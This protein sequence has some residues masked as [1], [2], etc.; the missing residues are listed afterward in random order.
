[1]LESV[2]AEIDEFCGF[3][4]AEDADDAAVVV[5]TIVLICKFLGHRVTNVRSREL[6]Q[7]SRRTSRGKSMATCPSSSMRSAASR[8]TLPSSLAP[9]LYCL[10]V[11]RTAARFVGET[12]TMAR[13]PRSE[14][15]AYSAAEF[16]V[17]EIEAPRPFATKQ[18][19]ESVTA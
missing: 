4:V 10:A 17:N 19:S 13:A 8:V 5:K 15:S 1:M 18:D 7:T 9:T 3:G 14:K 6:A 12:E 11:A 16:S 2:E